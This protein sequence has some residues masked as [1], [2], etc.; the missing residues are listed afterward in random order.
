MSS[1]R[2]AI[3]QG[4]SRRA[5]L[6]GAGAL[7]AAP[8]L[9]DFGGKALAQAA[10]P[11][12]IT[13]PGKGNYHTRL[14]LLGTAG[15]PVWYPR[16]NRV[17]TSTALVVGDTIYLIDLG[18][19]ATHRMAEAFNSG[20]FANTPGGKVEE[21]HS[22]FLQHADALLQTEERFLGGIL[23]DGHDDFVKKDSRPPDEI[24]MA[25]CGRIK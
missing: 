3:R 13:S 12:V 24:Q 16:S 2:E 9:T 8:L 20:I 21:A 14:V 6:Q 5:F 25:V 1:I 11:E 22:S 7:A 10:S 23:G 15:G 17:S 19:G 4:I 18:H